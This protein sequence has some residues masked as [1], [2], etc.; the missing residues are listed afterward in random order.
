MDIEEKIKRETW[1]VLKQLK[2]DMLLTPDSEH[3]RYDI[4]SREDNI[5]YPSL[6]NQRKIINKLQSI[7]VLEIVRTGY[8]PTDMGYIGSNPLLELQGYKP[9]NIIIKI[10]EEMFKKIF[11][12][13]EKNYSSMDDVKNINLYITK[14]DDDFYYNGLLIKRTNNNPYKVFNALYDRLQF[15]GEIPYKELGKDIKSLIKTTKNYTELEMTS[16]IQ[17][18]LTDKNNGFLHYANIKENED[19]GKPLI[20]VVRGKG[21]IFNNKKR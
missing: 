11:S 6:E 20:S 17:R 1:E 9:K 3:V 10:K 15:G 16:F 18:N 21:I 13:Y 12:E 19:N 8:L 2:I 5:N 4:L 14:K 7:G